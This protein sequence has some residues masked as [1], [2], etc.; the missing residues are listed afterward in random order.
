LPEPPDILSSKKNGWREI[1]AFLLTPVATG[2]Y[3]GRDSIGDLA[4]QFKLP[5]GFGERQQMLVNVLQSAIVYDNFGEV[6]T[7]LAGITAVYQ[8][9]YSANLPHFPHDAALASQWQ[10]RAAQ[11][12]ELFTKLQTLVV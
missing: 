12:V 5:R 3:L 6:M 2:I 10:A 4:K 7:G 9:H 11:T 8:T 1:S